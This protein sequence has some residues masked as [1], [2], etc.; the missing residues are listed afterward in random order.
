M[1]TIFAFSIR[2]SPPETRPLTSS[3]SSTVAPNI[4]TNL[5]SRRSTIS[6]FA[7]STASCARRLEYTNNLAVERSGSVLDERLAIGELDGEGHGGEDID[8]FESI[9]ND[10][11]VNNMGEESASDGDDGDGA[12]TGAESWDLE[13]PM[14]ILVMMTSP[15]EVE[16][17]LSM[18]RGPRRVRTVS[19]MSQ[20]PLINEFSGNFNSI[21]F[22]Q[23]RALYE[24][25][26]LS[27]LF[28]QHFF[29]GCLGCGIQNF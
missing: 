16:F 18:P 15:E 11:R 24:C 27:I 26:C 13:S 1:T 4:F 29:I 20:K 6:G 12:V 23:F 8:G 14:S 9:R 28:L 17:I 7:G 19:A 3:V 21:A 2:V 22:L 25:K 5:I 10:C